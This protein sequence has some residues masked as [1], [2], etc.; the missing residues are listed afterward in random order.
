MRQRLQIPN[1]K[2][3]IAFAERLEVVLN[4]PLGCLLNN[5]AHLWDV[6]VANIAHKVLRNYLCL[7]L[8]MFHR[9]AAHD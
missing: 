3:D 2:I 4:F 7:K 9:D 8:F 5:G 6:Q 1:T